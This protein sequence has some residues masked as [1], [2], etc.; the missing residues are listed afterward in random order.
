MKRLLGISWGINTLALDNTAGK[1]KV[2]VYDFIIFL[3]F[4]KL[5]KVKVKLLIGI[6]LAVKPSRS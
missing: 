2:K 1:Y 6:P 4:P 3:I 5:N